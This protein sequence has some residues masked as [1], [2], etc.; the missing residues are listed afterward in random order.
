MI[1]KCDYLNIKLCFFRNE[2][3]DTNWSKVMDPF[4]INYN[5]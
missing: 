1:R 2:L 4:I 5:L 3:G